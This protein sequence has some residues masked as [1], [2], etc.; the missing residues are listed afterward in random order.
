MNPQL[1]QEMYLTNP[2]HHTGNK[3]EET[4]KKLIDMN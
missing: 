1:Q 3:Q 2:E 4:L